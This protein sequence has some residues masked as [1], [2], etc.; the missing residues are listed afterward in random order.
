MTEYKKKINEDVIKTINKEFR[1]EKNNNNDQD[2]FFGIIWKGKP[3]GL[4][5]SFLTKLHLN[6]T[7]YQITD[8]ELIITTGFF[9][10]KQKSSELYCLKDPDMTQNLYQQWLNIGTITVRV[11]SA[12][13]S[14]KRGSV[15]TLKNVKNA[16]RVRKVLRD[17][18]EDDVMERKITYFDKI[19]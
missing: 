12:Q 4:L 10:K 11:D 18:I 9:I 16:D 2:N 5:Q 13:N 6:F 3:S 8:D 19:G 17:A 15:L 1:K 14:E 7:T